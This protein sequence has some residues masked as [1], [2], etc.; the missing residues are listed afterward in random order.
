MAVY[1]GARLRTQALRTQALPARTAGRISRG[2]PAAAA[3]AARVRPTTALMG[4]V[5]AGTLL[6]LVYLT[7]TL[8]SNAASA[9]I[10]GLRTR[11]EEL[12]RQQRNQV[13]AVQFKA[14]PVQVGLRAKKLGLV[15]LRDAEILPAP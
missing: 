2:S 7:Q 12:D 6:G 10:V 1:Q 4:I 15:R 5:L 11:A 14:D 8:G 13:A 3:A 9:E